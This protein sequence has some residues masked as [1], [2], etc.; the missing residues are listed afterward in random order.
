MG[1][2]GMID[3]GNEGCL[4]R[5]RAMILPK[6]RLTEFC[7]RWQI[8]ELAIFGSV[9]REDFNAQSDLDVLVSF[10]PGSDWSLFDHLQMQEELS[11]A[12]GRPVDLV[13]RRAIERSDNWI[14]R[15]SILESA[16]VIYAEG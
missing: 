16:Q 6:R 13:S 1:G 3:A 5:K 2:Y 7:R 10:A 15:G 14:R 11:A 9:L 8:T 4:M 12:T